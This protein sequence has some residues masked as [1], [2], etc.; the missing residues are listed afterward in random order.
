MSAEL[1]LAVSDP[2]I[3]ILGVLLLLAGKTA[4]AYIL[5]RIGGRGGTE[6]TRFAL[7]L[8]QGSEFS[9]VLFSAAVTVG[10]LSPRAAGLATLVI[11][12][13]MAATPILFTLAERFL[14]PRMAARGKQPVYD[15]IPES[16][17]PVIICGFGRVGQVV[18]RILRMQNIPFTALEKDAS[19]IEGV[20][21]FGYKV[22]YG[23]P[24]R[25][26]LLRAAGAET[27]KLM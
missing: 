14:L 27:A 21:R 1:N 19:Q 3:I 13:S 7:A 8:P 25:P 17:A 6:A 18:G 23:D 20:R 22:Y 10:V 24:S 4:V 2:K 12:L 16:D 26:D 15:E 5:A 11:A 9:F